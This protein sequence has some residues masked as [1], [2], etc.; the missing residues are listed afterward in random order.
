MTKKNFIL[1]FFCVSA[2]M[3][4]AEISIHG[5]D[6]L[7]TKAAEE[8]EVDSVMVVKSL[9]N[10][11]LVYMVDEGGEPSKFSWYQFDLNGGVELLK[12]EAEAVT[13]TEVTIS[14]EAHSMGYAVLNDK[15][16]VK[17]TVWI[18]LYSDYKP[19]N[20][21]V[22]FDSDSKDWCYIVNVFFHKDVKA[23]EYVNPGDAEP[24]F[25]LK[26]QYYLSYDSTYYESQ[27]YITE[28]IG[29]F[30]DDDYNYVLPAPLD[31]TKFTFKGTRFSMAFDDTVKVVSEATYM[32]YA[33]ET[34]MLSSVRIREDATNERDR[35]EPR[36]AQE[37]VTRLKGSAP[38]NV[39]VL[40]YSSP[41][42]FFYDWTLS[43]DN[44]Y[45]SV[46]AKIKDR[47][48][49]YTF[50]ESGTYYLKGEVSNSSITE[51]DNMGCTQ[52]KEFVIEVLTSALDVPNVFTPN[53]D[54]KNDIFKVAYKSI[55]KFHGSVYNTWGRL[56]Y[57]WDDPSDGWDG[58]I[59]GKPAAEG[60]YLYIIEATGDD[61][62]EKGNRIKYVKKGTVSLI[63]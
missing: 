8:S 5:T 11:N 46:I 32:P 28:E 38:L 57:D 39:E 40:N 58:T 47:D 36:E 33:V 26:Q 24:K 43:S 13:E 18:F 21:L 22:T 4:H 44:Q 9:E 6:Y 48:F 62:D 56:V 54:G 27:S 2:V 30:V 15:N 60:A 37:S 29:Y 12:Q 10:V 35:G 3:L 51:M 59:N 7:V 25:T 23:M 42:A 17:M 34:H 14:K 19:S 55:I 50:S 61:K 63:R 20:C 1:L 49:R 45:K 16:E 41:A 53:G 31:S 52:R